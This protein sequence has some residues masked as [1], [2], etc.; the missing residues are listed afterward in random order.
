MDLVKIGF[1]KISPAE[2]GRADAVALEEIIPFGDFVCCIGRN[3][4]EDLIYSQ[5]QLLFFM[6]TKPL[7]SSRAISDED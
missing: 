6:H 4:L 2:T 3:G 1:D 7:S 5:W